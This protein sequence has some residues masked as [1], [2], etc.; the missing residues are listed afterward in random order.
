MKISCIIPV[1]N[2]ESYLEAALDSVLSQDWPLHEIIAVD[3]GSTDTSASLLRRYEPAVAIVTSR[4][5]GIPAARN[6]GLR[7]ASGDVIAFQDADDLWPP[8]R[9]KVMAEL[10]EHE[11]S[12]DVLAGLVQIRNERSVEPADMTTRHRFLLASLLIRRGVFDRIGPFNE[13]LEVGED[14]EFVMRARHKGISF[15]LIDQ[16]AMIYRLHSTNIS[17]NVGRNHS[18]AL[19]ALRVITQLKRRS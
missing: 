6:A 15:K 14:T 7:Q 16:V 4:H 9:L 8:G 2:S 17:Q 11:P 10:L 13:E 19:D 12:V 5:A 3:D 1:Y 18:N